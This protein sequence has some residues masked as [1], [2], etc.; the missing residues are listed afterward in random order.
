MKSIHFILIAFLF[1]IAC[2][3]TKDEEPK[4]NT[5]NVSPQL[6]LLRNHWNLNSIISQSANFTVT[7][8]GTNGDYFE[9]KS[10]N[11]CVTFYNSIKDSVT[12]LFINDSTFKFDEN[13]AKITSLNATNFTF[14]VQTKE[15]SSEIT[16]FVNLSK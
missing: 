8:L 13:T 14:Q 16:T 5:Q 10:N 1:F 11:S 7:T 2:K 6:L 9:F 12:Y 15:D 4:S 3:K